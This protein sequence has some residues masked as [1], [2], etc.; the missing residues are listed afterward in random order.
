M[1]KIGSE[2]ITYTGITSTTFTGCVRGFSG[3]TSYQGSNTPDELVFEDTDIDQHKSGTTVTNLSVL[4]LKQFFTK[5]KKQIT[6]GFE[7]RELYTGLDE[8]IFSSN[9]MT[10][11][12]QRCRSIL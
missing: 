11:T 3:V 1:I 8:R 9:L 12:P 4:F 5:V 10:F 2:V 7:N 6:P